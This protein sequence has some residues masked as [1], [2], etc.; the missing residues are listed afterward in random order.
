MLYHK[1][2]S[3]I[4][5][6]AVLIII[7]N[8]MTNIIIITPQQNKNT[9]KSFIS[10]SSDHYDNFT[11]ICW[12]SYLLSSVITHYSKNTIKTITKNI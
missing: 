3:T 5:T 11:M 2:I 12:I 6:T 4:S 1:V 8:V 9:K 10:S 7:I